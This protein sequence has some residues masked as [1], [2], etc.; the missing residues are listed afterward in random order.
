MKVT[1]IGHTQIQGRSAIELKE[2]TGHGTP[3]VFLAQDGDEVSMTKEEARHFGWLL[4]EWAKK[5]I[6]SC[7]GQELPDRE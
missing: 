7:C 6:C 5:E 2:I 1:A 3:R 4:S